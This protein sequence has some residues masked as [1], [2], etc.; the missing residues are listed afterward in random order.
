LLALRLPDGT[1]RELVRIAL[2]SVGL[3]IILTGAAT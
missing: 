2:N 3:T 1:A